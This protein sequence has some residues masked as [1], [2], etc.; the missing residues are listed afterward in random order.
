MKV[1]F[2]FFFFTASAVAGPYAPEVGAVG[3]TAI[4]K[5]DAAFVAWATVVEDYSVGAEVDAVWQD[6]SEALGQAEGLFDSVVV[7]G[8]GGSITLGFE[9]AIVDG[10]GADFAVFE[11]AISDF[12]L[13]LAFVEVSEDGVNYVRFA[14]DSQTAGPVSSFGFVDPTDV[15]G[16][17]G[18][19]RLGY[20][21]P[22]DLAEVGLASA[23]FVRLVDVVG[24]T[25]TDT[26]GDVIY[27]PYP[28]MV[29]AGFDLDGVGV[30]H[31]AAPPIEI[32]SAEV[33]G[34]QFV[35]EWASE[36]GEE[37][38]VREW[39]EVTEEWDEVETVTATGFTGQV[40]LAVAGFAKRLVRVER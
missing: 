21:V 19:Y 25:N 36:V 34:G 13:E 2:L 31:Q 30:I 27:D 8:R 38:V 9:R 12:F 23:R 14:N 11:N 3:T 16:L 1:I 5:D 18:K 26:S 20:G 15:T 33:T 10:A 29:S 32:L 40:S 4:A 39:N 35:V 28:T 22:F 24:G 17:A 37:Y 7:L 6:T